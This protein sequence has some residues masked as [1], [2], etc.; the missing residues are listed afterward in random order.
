MS[1][2]S[3]T[4]SVSN[5]AIQFGDSDQRSSMSR[6]YGLAV[7]FA[8]IDADGP[9]VFFMDPSGTFVG[10]DAKAIGAGGEGAQ[11]SLNEGYNKV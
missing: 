8:G 4:Q 10:C 3:C 11:Q 7:L 2:E 6:P 5:L 1:V 9:A